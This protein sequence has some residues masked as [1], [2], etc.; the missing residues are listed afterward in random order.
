MLKITGQNKKNAE[1]INDE[2]AERHKVESERE[3]C[4]QTDRQTNRVRE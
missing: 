3:R 1:R 4:R 2:T